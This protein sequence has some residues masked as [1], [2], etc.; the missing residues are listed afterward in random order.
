MKSCWISWQE[1]GLL[2][3]FQYGRVR[4]RCRR[5]VHISSMAEA[6]SVYDVFGCRQQGH[7][8]GQSMWWW[9]Y[10]IRRTKE[11]FSVSIL[12]LAEFKFIPNKVS[13]P[14]CSFEWS[15]SPVAHLLHFRFH[16]HFHYHFQL[17][18]PPPLPLLLVHH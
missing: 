18:L 8:R 17:L 2:W 7:Q 12:I 14:F 1:R 16:F 4:Y 5:D 3:L 15:F 11:E 13:I 6:A 9:L 10:V